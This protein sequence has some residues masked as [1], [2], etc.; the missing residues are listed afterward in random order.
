MARILRG[1]GFRGLG[2]RGLGCLVQAVMFG[3]L[4]SSAGNLRKADG[5]KASSGLWEA[6]PQIPPSS[7]KVLE[8][9]L[10]SPQ[11]HRLQTLH[12]PTNR[13]PEQNP[14]PLQIPP[15]H[16]P[17]QNPNCPKH[18]RCAGGRKRSTPSSRRFDPG[19]Q[20]V[21]GFRFQGFR[22]SGSWGSMLRA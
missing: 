17:E 22:V 13:K 11:A 12:K 5:T 20:H 1:L 19:L 21:S 14:Q 7:P 15:K 9:T 10:N 4:L 2:F 8:S 3:H 18:L 16:R 6:E